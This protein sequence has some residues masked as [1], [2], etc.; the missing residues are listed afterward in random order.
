MTLFNNVKVKK[1]N[2]MVDRFN[3]VV[4]YKKMDYE[5][6][7]ELFEKIEAGIFNTDRIYIDPFF[8]KEQA[9]IRYLNWVKSEIEK[10]TLFFNLIYKNKRIGFFGLEEKSKG[11]YVSF[12]GGIY[13]EHQ[14]GGIGSVIKAPDAVR[15]LGGTRVYASASSNN[16][17]Q[18]R[19]LVYNGYEI[20]RCE[21]IFIKHI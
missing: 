5:A 8:S 9:S 3:S 16:L 6:I 17:S 4:T 20:E 12:L 2:K 21:H 10:G 1:Y 13:R 11:I 18:I 14:I 15:D 19:N 7:D